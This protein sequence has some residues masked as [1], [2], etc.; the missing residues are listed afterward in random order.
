MCPIGD[1]P[2]IFFESNL[3]IF[4]ADTNQLRPEMLKCVQTE[5]GLNAF[6]ESA[7]G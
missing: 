5:A 1:T 2:R 3:S 4:V 7:G 6:C